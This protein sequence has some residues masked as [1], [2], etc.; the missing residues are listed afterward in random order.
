MVLLALVVLQMCH[1]GDIAGS[2]SVTNVSH[3][4]CCWHW[5]C[6]KRVTLVVLFVQG[7]AEIVQLLLQNDEETPVHA[8]PLA[9]DSEGMTGSEWLDAW[10]ET[11][12]QMTPAAKETSQPD[13]AGTMA[14]TRVL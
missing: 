10:F 8:N 9:D 1:V 11:E 4:W 2:G 5:L 6:Y 7:H 14:E 13:N 3:G 12:G